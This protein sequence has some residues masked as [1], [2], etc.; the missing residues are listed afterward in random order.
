MSKKHSSKQFKRGKKS[1][2]TKQSRR[3]KKKNRQ[4]TSRKFFIKGGYNNEEIDLR[5]I[6][7]T[8]P[9]VEAVKS[10]KEDADLSAFK[11]SKG[12][13]GFKLTRMERMNESNFEELIKNEPVELKIAR[14]N[15]GKM[16]GL[17]IDGVTKKSYEI[18]N[19]RHRISKAIIDGRK[20]INAIIID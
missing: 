5:Q 3:I 13:Q 15:E 19:G 11:M 14:N 4:K 16:I 2:A 18:I 20:T 12:E 7:I 8:T 10:I 6:L 17:K 9:I 1:K